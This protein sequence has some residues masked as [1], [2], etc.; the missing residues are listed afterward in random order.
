MEQWPPVGLIPA[1][2]YLFSYIPYFAYRRFNSLKEFIEAVLNSQISMLNYHA[3]PGL[4][5]DHPFYS[6]WWQWPVIG[7]PMYY[8]AYE[9]LPA[10]NA[11]FHS[12]FA[13]GNPVI[14]YGALAA[15]AVCMIRAYAYSK[16]PVISREGK[17]RRKPDCYDPRY[18]FILVG[19]LAQYLPWVL[20]PRGT[21]IYHYF[22][23]L[24]FL[25]ASIALCSDSRYPKVRSVLRIASIV[26]IIA[27]T[28]FFVLLFPYA[29]G[30]NTSPEWLGIGSRFLR[31]WY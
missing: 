18:V 25:M 15:F 3:T 30:M 2:I 31:I 4:G 7:K 19:L 16:Y 9:Y 28:V 14:W 1:V 26:F 24:P 23:S 5:M 10:D 27:A 20:V 21:Y 22:A 11:V 12:I 6:P 8:A 17:M 29:S 13:F